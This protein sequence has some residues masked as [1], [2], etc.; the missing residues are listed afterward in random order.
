VGFPDI[1]PAASG[2][3]LGDGFAVTAASDA[4]CDGT[5]TFDLEFTDAV[6]TTSHD[7]WS[8]EIGYGVMETV[9]ADDFETDQGW[10][11]TG[12]PVGGGRWQRGDPVGSRDGSNQANPE[13]DSPN[14]AGS[15]C[16]VT[17][18]GFLLDPPNAHDVDAVGAILWS[19]HMDLTGYKRAVL[20]FDLWFYDSSSAN[21][22]QDYGILQHYVDD[23]L[24]HLKTWYFY[25][26]TNGWASG[27]VH[28]NR[29][30][31]MAPNVRMLFAAYDKST[32]DIVE[33]GV[34]NVRVEGERQ[35]CDL[36]GVD[37]PPNGIGDTLRIDRSAGSVALTWQASPVDGAHDGAAYYEL[38]SSSAAAGGFALI[39][40]ATGTSIL[41]PLE[42]VTEY[43]L[44]TAVNPAGTSGDEPTP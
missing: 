10:T 13:D 31:P 9:F 24:L 37:N 40:T 1:D 7:V 43:Y 2:T 32:D 8:P 29:Y 35:V 20:T 15:Q 21:A 41:N 30:L 16:F 26:P 38:F 11:V 39:D 12:A 34:D 6:G 36:P 25:Y 3:S 27:I 5:L 44:L 22:T 14:D 33:M 4:G 18:N 19:P 42:P 28:L 23:V 17:E